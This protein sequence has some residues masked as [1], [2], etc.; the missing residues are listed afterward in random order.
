MKIVPSVCLLA[1]TG[2]ALAFPSEVQAPDARDQKVE[3]CPDGQLRS[4]YVSSLQAAGVTGKATGRVIFDGEVPETKELNITEAQSAGCT[5]DGSKV[6]AKDYSLLVG[7]DKGIANAVVTIELP[8]QKLVVPEEPIVLD[9]VQCRF[10]QHV[11]LVPVGATIEYR[12]S[13]SVPHNVHTY[14]IKNT[15]FNR[16]LAAKS[17]HKQL[18]E[19]AETIQIKCDI[20]P[21]MSTFVF[22]AD[23]NFAALT[24]EHGAFA[25]PGL[26]PGEYTARVWHEKLG[27]SEVKVVI[28]ETGVSEPVSVAMKPKA[29]RRRS[30]R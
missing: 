10:T 15:A 11:V 27:K 4:V 1:C 5:D 22:A 30:R 2:L 24:D 7:E 9:Q 19:E 25:I 23:T 17:S 13:D 26:P 20:H 21:W 14:S 16:T 28:G 29:S 18:I 8:D 12:N 6:L 3:C